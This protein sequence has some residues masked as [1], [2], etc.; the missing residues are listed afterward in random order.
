MKRALLVAAGLLVLGVLV[1]WLWLR[2]SP[3][4]VI[5]GKIDRL[6]KAVRID[7]A[8]SPLQRHARINDEFKDIFAKDLAIELPDLGPPRAGRQEIVALAVQATGIWTSVDLSF[9]RVDI[10][11]GDAR[12]TATVTTTATLVVTRGGGAPERETRDVTFRFDLIDGD[13]RV[14]A[15]IVA[16]RPPPPE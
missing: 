10:K 15:V 14:V 11:L 5:E 6:G 1:W 7:A 13:F 12:R 4:K 3:E 8:E 9:S 16:P 2:P